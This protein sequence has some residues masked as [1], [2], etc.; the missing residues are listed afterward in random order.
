M[1]AAASVESWGDS[2]LKDVRLSDVSLS[3]V[4]NKD[5]EIVGRTPRS[6]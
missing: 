6:H 1:K 2:S 5:Q 4:G 3:Y